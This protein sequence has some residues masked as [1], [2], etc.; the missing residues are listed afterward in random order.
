MRRVLLCFALCA[1]VFAACDNDNNDT[2]SQFSVTFGKLE[3]VTTDS[4]VTITTSRPVA[5]LNDT[6][7]IVSD[8]DLYLAYREAGQDEEQYLT[9]VESEGDT[10]C[11]TLTELKPE[12]E[13]TA[14]LWYNA[15]MRGMF[16][17]NDVTFTTL[18]PVPEPL[19]DATELP[20]LSGLYFGNYYG[21]TEHD[22]NYSLA[23]STV[24]NCFDIITGDVLVLDNSQYLFLDIYADV[25]AAEYNV[26]FTVPTGTYTLDTTDSAVAGTVSSK[27]SSLY[28]TNDTTGVEVFFT[29]G[30]VT[31]TTDYI[32]AALVGNDGNEYDFLCPTATVDNSQNFAPT[33]APGEQ[34][35]LDGDVSIPFVNAAIFTECY[36]DYYVIGKDNWLLFVKDED[37]GD[38]ISFELLTTLNAT[39]P[40]GRF[41]VTRDLN[42]P[43]MTLPGYVNAGE[44][45]WS[46]YCFYADY[47]TITASAPINSGEV[48]IAENSDGTLTVKIDV[49]DDMGYKITG[50]CRSNP[51]SLNS[52]ADIRSR[53]HLILK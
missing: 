41:P 47:S 21:A 40:V 6:D 15:G 50:E 53:K 16:Q 10:L 29:S 44:T 48:T 30:T 28:T 42:E 14:T 51:I 31:V 26:R 1:I 49:I 33:F 24:A 20:H 22:Y 36:G 32:Y 37:T 25:P 11:F 34:S 45:M 9:E 13:Y 27:Y 7:Y 23:L 17:S 4:T 52:R 35:T 12:T 39:L 19:P 46:W 18:A 8:S 5:T 38:T 3:C 2:K 43:Q